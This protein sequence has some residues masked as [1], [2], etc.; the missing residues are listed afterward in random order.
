QTPYLRSVAYQA[1]VVLLE[2][3]DAPRPALPVQSRNVY[4]VLFRQPAIERIVSAAGDQEP[5]VSTSTLRIVGARFRADATF[6]L[7]DGV[8]RVPDDLRDDEVR[9]KVPADVPVGVHAVQ[10]VQ[11]QLMG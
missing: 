4:V 5:I 8:E 11:K 7:L 3:D 9:L 6:V 10:I 1:S 2:T